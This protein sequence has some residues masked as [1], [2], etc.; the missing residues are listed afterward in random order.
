M[1]SAVD[2]TLPADTTKA[3][4]ADFRAQFLV[5]YNEI[6]ALQQRTGVAGSEAFS[7]AVS[8]QEVQQEIRKS[9]SRSTLARDM[10]Y[11]RVSLTS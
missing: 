1:T 2:I 9:N 4:K 8:I 6:T 11:G 7:D 3:V 5:I 10:A